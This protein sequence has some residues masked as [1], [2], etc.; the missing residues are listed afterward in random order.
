M[1]VPTLKQAHAFLHPLSGRSSAFVVN[2]RG[3]NRILANFALGCLSMLR[4]RTLILD[5]SCF[6]GTNAAALTE[7]LPA[8]FL[9]HTIILT[10]PEGARP[11]DVM[12]SLVATR[13][14]KVII[15]DDLNTLNSLISSEDGKSGTHKLFIL[16]RMLSYSAKVNGLSVITTIYK[17]QAQ[18]M[19]ASRRSLAAAS[20]LEISVRGGSSSVSFASKAADIWSN[21]QF[22]ASTA[23]HS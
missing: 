21:G 15:I 8:S 13:Q 16:I 17:T 23:F 9:D 7:N 1:S 11:E 5:T 6:Y 18:E 2:S 22:V 19:R 4:M 3:E 14:A 10:I 12:T 20:D